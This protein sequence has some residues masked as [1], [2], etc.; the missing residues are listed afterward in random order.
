MGQ[1]T[2]STKDRILIVD[3]DEVILF[4]F[5]KVLERDE[6]YEIVTASDARHALHLLEAEPTFAVMLTDMMMPEMSGLDLACQARQVA[7]RMQTV[8]I[9]AAGTMENAIAAR[10]EA[11]VW[12]YV[13]KPL[14][15][16]SELCLVVERAMDQYQL[17]QHQAVTASHTL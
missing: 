9:T 13:L 11:R 2:D 4:L 12:D 6:R 3:D 17:L 10:L 5:R 7:P 1:S 15:S 14:P 8:V 16:L